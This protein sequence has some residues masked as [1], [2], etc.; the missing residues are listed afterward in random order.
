MNTKAKAQLLAAVV[1]V[2]SIISFVALAVGIVHYPM[3]GK[4][5]VALAMLAFVG[6]VV[7]II[8][9]LCYERYYQKLRRKELMRKAEDVSL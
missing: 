3:F 1:T 5:I 6:M 2:V 8:Y 9:S 7:G 4:G